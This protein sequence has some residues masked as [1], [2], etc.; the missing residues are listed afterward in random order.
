MKLEGT[1]AHA[2][3]RPQRRWTV[4]FLTAAL[5]H[6]IA[7][8]LLLPPWM[9]EDEPW[10]FEYIRHVADGNVPHWAGGGP[11]S[12]EDLV[13]ATHSQLQVERRFPSASP[14]AVADLQAV[15]TQAMADGHF[16]ERVDWADP[17]GAPRSFEPPW[18]TTAVNQPPLYY[19]LA[20]A[21]VSA[22]GLHGVHA[23]LY[24]A[25]S[26]SLASYLAVVALALAAARA[27]FRD[28][29][30]ALL[31]A[32]LAA[33]FPI[34]ARQAAAVSN[35]VLAKL[36]ASVVFCVAARSVAVTVRPWERWAAVGA[37]ALGLATK[38]TTAT[39]LGVL[40]LALLLG[41][42]DRRRVCIGIG[43][44][45][46]LTVGAFLLWTSQHNHA[47]PTSLDAVVQ[48]LSTGLSFEN[49]ERLWFSSLGTFNA[50]GR[51]LPQAVY[52]LFGGIA[53]AAV[54]LSVVALI[55]SPART[56]VVRRVLF[57][58]LGAIALQVALVALHGYGVGRYLTPALVP[59]AI[60]VAAGLVALV[61][62]RW[63]KAAS[64]A[65]IV[66]ILL[67]DVL[68]LWSGL[69]EHQYLVWKE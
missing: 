14:R 41:R 22:S 63:R 52:L 8:L 62:S 45:G 1:L 17:V 21:V 11:Y 47:V 69:I 23:Q 37:C 44:L 55:R 7:Y 34:H 67:Y 48:R 10:H 4:L 6:G 57:L 49:W 36:L 66:S 27:A 58:S 51:Y 33:W 59:V 24:V 28:P 39:S 12:E 30:I 60:V 25:R 20:G 31:A 42:V 26:L 32:T 16:W 15:L 54:A 3:E 35:D 9:G 5:L 2:T 61:P 50:N 53:L 43:L 64:L 46:A 38:T 68:F 18:G 19:L 29:S 65:G 13:R 56:P 40:C